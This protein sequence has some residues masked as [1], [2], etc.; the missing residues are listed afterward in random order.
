MSICVK[1]L[2]PLDL[3]PQTVESRPCGCWGLNPGPLE[4]QPVLVLLTEPSLQ[5]KTTLL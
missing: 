1:V 3:E 5:P 4:E 2:D